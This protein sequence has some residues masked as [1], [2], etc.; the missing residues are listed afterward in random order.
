MTD[1]RH[2]PT[3]DDDLPEARSVRSRWPGLVWAIPLAALIIVAFLGVRALTRQGVEVKVTFGNAE[4]VT[5][6]NTK[7]LVSGV[8]AGEVSKVRV[9]PDGHHVEVT[10]KLDPREKAA[11]NSNTKFWLIGENPSITD[12]QSI[13]AAVA[14]VIIAMAPGTG[15]APQRTFTGLDQPPIVPPDAKGTTYFITSKTGSIQPGASVSYHGLAIGKVVDNGLLGF[16]HFRMRMF[17]N[18]PYDRLIKPGA[19]FWSGSPLKLS[20][21]GAS[22]SAGL[23]SPAAVL[24]GS[25]QFE[26]PHDARAGPQVPEGA[27]FTLYDDEQTAEQGPTG[28]EIAYRMLLNGEAGDLAPNASVSMLGYAVGRVRGAKLR[29][30]PGGKPYTEATIALYPRKLDIDLPDTAPHDDWRTATDRTVSRLLAQ[31]YRV[32]LVQSPPLVGAHVVQLSA[33]RGATPASLGHDGG[34]YPLLPVAEGGGGADDLV[35]SA[36]QILQKINRIPIEQIGDNLGKIS[37]NIAQISG[38]GQVRD[39]IAH[40]DGTLR[41]LDAILTEVKPQIGP[42]MTKLNQTAD[43]LHGTAAAARTVLSG[44]GAMQDRSLPDA[45]QQIDEMSRSIRSLTDYLGRHPE[46]LIRGKAK[47]KK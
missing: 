19:E 28:P 20:L 29:F 2:Q 44:E 32:H 11:L 33:D 37:A 1:D 41:Q 39:S 22:I 27:T 43:E 16:D 15:G 38:S 14:G 12:I 8:E 7:V 18:A 31:G 9:S 6:G 35:A 34:L 5:P 45:I 24:Q 10:L 30:A 17:I 3:G 23:S 26:L 36:N 4:G 46:A 25:V 40:L 13:R 47:E 42:L 21:S